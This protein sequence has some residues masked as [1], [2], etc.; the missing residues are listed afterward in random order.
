LICSC[1]VGDGEWDARA[2]LLWLGASLAV[3][4]VVV[5][6]SVPGGL[7]RD[8]RVAMGWMGLWMWVRGFWPGA[9]SG[10]VGLMNLRV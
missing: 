1:C 5:A 6:G 2:A 4:G 3:V 8:G 7:A 10:V 9:P